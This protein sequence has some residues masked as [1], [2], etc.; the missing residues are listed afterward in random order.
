MRVR[1]SLAALVALSGCFGCGGPTTATPVKT[2]AP[3]PIATGAAT[4][5]EDAHRVTLGHGRSRTASQSA[6]DWVTYAEHVVVITVVAEARGRPSAAEIER[7]EGLVPRTAK[8]SV[9]EVLWSSPKPAQAAPASIELDVAGW[10]FNDNSGA[11]EAKFAIEGH[12]RFEPKH[13]YVWALDWVDDPCSSDPSEGSWT[14]LG[15][16]GAI[17]YDDGVLGVGEFEGRVYTLQ[18]A[19][20][21]WQAED[22]HA[23]GLRDEV[24]GRDATAVADLLNRAV[25]RRA[26]P[27]ESTECDL[28][29]R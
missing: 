21:A 1:A 8:L 4:E 9:D 12:P 15:D 25:P 18:E 2:L 23:R 14:G 29:E 13:S 27:V 7:Q 16:G 11:G 26:Q 10:I 3:Q 6:E 22:P 17:P 19:V 28:S 24:M 5:D 20:A